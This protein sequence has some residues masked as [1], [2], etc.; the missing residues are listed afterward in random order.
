M[1]F[2]FSGVRILCVVL[3]CSMLCVC[4]EA[5]CVHRQRCIKFVVKSWDGGRYEEGEDIYQTTNK[6]VC[7]YKESTIGP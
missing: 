7:I 6:L 4:D 5:C 3:Q 1:F 2:V